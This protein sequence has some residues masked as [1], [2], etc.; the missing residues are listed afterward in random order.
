MNANKWLWDADVVKR[1]FEKGHKQGY[2]N[3]HIITIR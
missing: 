3:V 1:N 2:S